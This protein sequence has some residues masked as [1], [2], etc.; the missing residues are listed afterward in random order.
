[1]ARETKTTESSSYET[2]DHNVIRKWIEERKGRPASVKGTGRG[3][4]GILRVDFPGYGD[5]E[6]LEPI[7][8]EEFFR[9][10]DENNLKFLYQEKTADGK[11]SRFNKFIAR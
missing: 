1:M 4:A 8:W 5:D 9:K 7:S 2:T 6:A 11:I 3:E 10:F